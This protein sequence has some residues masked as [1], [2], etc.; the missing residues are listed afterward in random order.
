LATADVEGR[1]GRL[2]AG[3]GGAFEERSDS[4]RIPV[5]IRGLGDDFAPVAWSLERLRLEAG[6]CCFRVSRNDDAGRWVVNKDGRGGIDWEDVRLVDFLDVLAQGN[7][8]R[9]YAGSIPIENLE[10]LTDDARQAPFLSWVGDPEPIRIRFWL[11]RDNA[12][13]LHYDLFHTFLAPIVGSRDV[14]LFAPTA[15]DDFYP[16]QDPR[17]R[18]VSQIGSP[19]NVDRD[20]FPAFVSKQPIR[21]QLAPGEVLFMPIYWW[22]YVE[23]GPG[24]NAALSYHFFRPTV[25]TLRSEYLLD[26]IRGQQRVESTPAAES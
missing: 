12:T 19:K 8:R 11:G 24:V 25:E 4:L 21:L 17:N 16:M 6:D 1:L 5:H 22:H 15:L 10:P 7:P 23:S 9:L 3:E 2:T 14:W 18:N 20:A 26:Y 13:Q